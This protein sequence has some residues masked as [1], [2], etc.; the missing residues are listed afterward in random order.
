VNLLKTKLGRTSAVIAGSII[1]LAG[2]AVFASPASAHDPVVTGTPS[3]VTDAKTWNVDWE[4]GNDYQTDAKI[5]SIKL[6]SVGGGA[7]KDLTDLIKGKDAA[8]NPIGVNT[9]VPNNTRSDESNYANV[10]KATS[11]IPTSY[12]GVKLEINLVWPD[13]RKGDETKVLKPKTCTTP[14][15]EPSTPP[16]STPPTTSSPTPSQSTPDTP[17]VPVPTPSEGPEP[18]GIIE[19]DCTT[20]TIGLQVP[21]GYPAVTLE[22]KTTKGETRT[23]TI[24]PGETKTEKFSAVKGFSVRVTSKVTVDGQTESD[25]VDIPWQKPANCDTSGQGGGLPV[26]G[27]AAGGIAGGAAVLLVAGG[28]LFVMAR[29]RKVKFTA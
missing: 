20:E 8:G 18:K 10:L 6:T 26:T 17:E 7:S 4:I 11:E 23:D 2:V 3:C 27:A 28:V 9:V 29:R 15:E 24:Q 14:S 16:A 13:Y 21:K 25:F 12:R 22:F 1:G 19:F 5:E